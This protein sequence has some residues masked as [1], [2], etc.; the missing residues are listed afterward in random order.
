[1]ENFKEKLKIQNIVIAIAACILALF[2]FLSAAGE[3]GIIPFFNPVGGD[4]HWQSVW[5]GFISGAACALLAF[6]IFGLV[7]NIRAMHSEKEL[8]KLFVRENDE[9]MIQVWTYARAAAFQIFLILGLVAIVVSGYFSM[10][11]SITILAC[12][13]ATS[14]I[15]LL[16]K[17]YYNK[18]F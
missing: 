4:S 10:T 18:K 13:L 1:M 17:L 8:K 3:A 11:V 12:V 5:R 6:M 2:C 9:R 16:F 7:R 14:I 15:G